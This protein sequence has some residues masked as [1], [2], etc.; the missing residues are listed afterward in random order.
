[1]SEPRDEPAKEAAP[2]PSDE[3]LGAGVDELRAARVRLEQ[4]QAFL[5]DLEALPLAIGR[6]ALAVVLP[7]LSAGGPAERAAGKLAERIL[8]RFNREGR[9]GGPRA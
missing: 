9:E 8:E 3:D 5:E 2:L 7:L 6:A 1:M 4:Y